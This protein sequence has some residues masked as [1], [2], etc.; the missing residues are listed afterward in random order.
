MPET[1]SLPRGHWEAS[2][3]VHLPP[4][5]TPLAQTVPQAEHDI[6]SIDSVVQESVFAQ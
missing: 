3:H 1:Q 5:Q 4:V 2:S 6:G